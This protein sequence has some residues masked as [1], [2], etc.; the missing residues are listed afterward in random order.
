MRA[1]TDMTENEAR[2]DLAARALDKMGDDF[3]DDREE[4]AIDLMSNLLHM[5]DRW[6]GIEP[7]AA[8]RMAW[9]HFA[10]EKHEAE[11]VLVTVQEG[12]KKRRYVVASED[13]A[14]VLAYRDTDP[15]D[16]PW[17][18]YFG[19]QWLRGYGNVD[20]MYRSLSMTDVVKIETADAGKVWGR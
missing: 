6:Y 18:F 12:S 14:E 1:Q 20:E 19:A 13:A 11:V 5:L 3:S 10:A 7:E 16:R 4:A 2:A 17:M 15:D 8:H 9:H